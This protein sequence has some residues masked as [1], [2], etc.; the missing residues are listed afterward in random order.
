MPEDARDTA[1]IKIA[2]AASSSS[3][4]LNTTTAAATT[5]SSS[6]SGTTSTT[7]TTTT[8]TTTAAAGVVS[9]APPY[10]GVATRLACE[11]SSCSVEI[12]LLTHE[13]TAID[14]AR[15]A[16]SLRLARRMAMVAKRELGGGGAGLSGGV[17]G[18]SSG[19]GSGSGGS[20]G[21]GSGGGGS[22]GGGSGG[23]SE[24]GSEGDEPAIESSL[25]DQTEEQ[26]RARL[27]SERA[28]HASLVAEQTDRRVEWQRLVSTVAT[29][30]LEA[31]SQSPLRLR[32]PNLEPHLRLGA[33][34]HPAWRLPS[35][36][37]DG[38]GVQYASG[39][40]AAAVAV[41]IMVDVQHGALRFIEDGV[42]Q[43][44][45][46][47]A[48]VQSLFPGYRASHYRSAGVGVR[49]GGGGGGGSGGGAGGSAAPPPSE[50]C[51]FCLPGVRGAPPVPL[52]TGTPRERDQ[53]FAAWRAASALRPLTPHHPLHAGPLMREPPGGG[54]YWT[55]VHAVLL[56][57]YLLL[58][59]S[60][61][62]PLPPRS[63]ALHGAAIYHRPADRSL[64]FTLRGAG[65]HVAFSAKD[66]AS[67]RQWLDALKNAL[68]IGTVLGD[69][70]LGRPKRRPR[71]VDSLA[72]LGS[73]R[74]AVRA[75][76]RSV[77]EA[78][79]RLAI[80]QSAADAQ[81]ARAIEQLQRK[82]TP[83]RA[84]M[85]GSG[86][87]AKAAEGGGVGSLFGGG[88]GG[89][90]GGV[91]GGGGGGGGGNGGG[92]LLSGMLG[93]VISASNGTIL[94]S[95]SGGGGDGLHTALYG[96]SAPP[97]PTL[98]SAAACSAEKE[99]KPPPSD[100]RA[101]L[102]QLLLV[103]RALRDETSD[104][105]GEIRMLQ[106]AVILLSEPDWVR[107]EWLWFIRV[108]GA[109]TLWEVWCRA[110]ALHC[111]QQQRAA[112][113]AA[114]E[115]AAFKRRFKCGMSSS[116]YFRN[117]GFTNSSGGF[118]SNRNGADSGTPARSPAPVTPSPARG[119]G[120]VSAIWS[121]WRGSH[122]L[123]VDETRS[124]SV[125]TR[126]QAAIEHD[127]DWFIHWTNRV[128]EI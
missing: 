120:V 58:L 125:E 42:E 11:V 4:T 34:Y 33:T 40:A 54:L 79:G 124:V 92:G 113:A 119:P 128:F 105:D 76:Q 17:G 44:A 36:D 97:S 41:V 80:E 13:L 23:G 106:R 85:R 45:V 67:H 5:G 1:D 104:G 3:S 52:H 53:L 57:D 37:A 75:L 94:G 51:C 70:T 117:G 38:G 78:E 50:S 16:V 59:G 99:K 84:P 122:G 109:R 96:E 49:G 48:A 8:T 27:V 103:N 64:V 90:G 95:G 19:G 63:L 100:P 25:K 93:S 28:V 35:T 102:R 62:D 101:M 82:G 6:S 83:V 127:E 116:D 29:L 112:A 55:L 91:G 9:S 110:Y 87:N 30:P 118:D 43:S 24:G 72:E 46:P 14:A 69:G 88:Y 61:D 66:A 56:P 71:V 60:A 98:P 114:A 10:A 68:P 111:V 73:A 123:G 15:E 108:A 74:V 47:F 32:L 21:G 12:R 2:A 77:A 86:A 20:G 126:R 107:G 7:T 39:A 89:G 31:P 18:K 26:V 65:W 81:V 22:G 121:A 115:A